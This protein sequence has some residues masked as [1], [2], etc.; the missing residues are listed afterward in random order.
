MRG[1]RVLHQANVGLLPQE[2]LA[3]RSRVLLLCPS[4]G[5]GG[6][7]ERYVETLEWALGA[8]EISCQRV[9]LN[10]AGI[11]AHAAMLADA[12]ILLRGSSEPVRIVVGHQALLPVATLLA[13]EPS[14]CGIS[15]LCYG[16]EV[17]TAGL[18]PRRVLERSLMRRKDVHVVAISSFTA[19]ALGVDCHATILPPL[20]PRSGLTPLLPRPP[21]FIEPQDFILSPRFV[22]RPGG[23]RGSRS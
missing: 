16:Q 6:G 4:R 14:V 12:R 2:G 20:C 10:G 1:V 23:R 22:L 3:N 9:D 15:V 19:G 5:L 13:R 17:W 21:V 18:R 8:Q 7:I 11:R